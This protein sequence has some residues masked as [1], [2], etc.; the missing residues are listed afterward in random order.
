M[1]VLSHTW[2]TGQDDEVTHQDIVDYSNACTLASMANLVNLVSM[3]WNQ[4]RWDE[5]VEL[6][7]QVVEPSKTKLRADH[8]STPNSMNKLAFT[9]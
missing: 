1:A 2:G 6:E 3:L 4:G 9:L 5:A 7:L 8:P